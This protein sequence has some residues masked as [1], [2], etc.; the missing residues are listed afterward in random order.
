[1]F[2]LCSC[3]SVV[4]EA[5]PKYLGSRCVQVLISALPQENNSSSGSSSGSGSGNSSQLRLRYA[6]QLIVKSCRDVHLH[7]SES[8]T[9]A[10]LLA[11]QVSTQWCGVVWCGVVL[12][13]LV[14][15]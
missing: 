6:H 8:R 9:E 15:R 2:G 11:L 7:P 14:L 4:T 13:G 5:T 10:T 12:C 1:M 3:C